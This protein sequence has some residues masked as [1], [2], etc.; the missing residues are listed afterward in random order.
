MN[1][2]WPEVSLADVLTLNRSGF[3]GKG[4][5]E[6]QSTVPAR[7]VRNGDISRQGALRGYAE[8]LFSPR[9]ASAAGLRSGDILLTTSGEVGKAWLVDDPS[10]FFASNFV[11]ILRPD[12]ARVLPAFL[13]L[14]LETET[15]ADAL[16]SNTTGTTISNL[17]KRFYEAAHFALPS[18]SEQQ[19]IVVVLDEAFDAIATLNANVE[20][21]LKDSRALFQSCL[22][23]V[24]AQRVDG[25]M[26]VALGDVCG[27]VRGPFGG[28][29]KKSIFVAEGYAVYEQ[30]HAIRDQF[31][32]VRYFVDEAKFEE[33]KR[34]ELLPNDLIMSCSGTMGRV[35]IVP[36]CIKRGIINQA[37]LKLTPSDK[38]SCAFLKSWME[39]EAF[40]DALNHYAAGAA[41]QNVASVKVLKEIR[42]PLPAIEEQAR[43]VRELEDLR[44]EIQRLESVYH[45]KVTE[46]E[47]L[48]KSLL[49]RAFAGNL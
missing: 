42:V 2:A 46:L 34:F 44:V 27:F 23:T 17:Q 45:R 32:D 37:L 9:E 14:A 11:R 12:A 21:N 19:Q 25:W 13:R 31:D 16:R 36:Q 3:W 43:V 29:L 33:M 6:G 7:V 35:A 8:R 18:L 15:V 40:Q 38:I 20:Q 10:G 41:I 47:A 1:N 5:P 39:S 30:Q 49:H 48:K 28:S 4:L 24:F 22:R 26:E